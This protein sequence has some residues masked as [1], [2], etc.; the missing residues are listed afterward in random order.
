[1][2]R[3]TTVLAVIVLLAASGAHAAPSL[4][5]Q[6]AVFDSAKGQFYVDLTFLGLPEAGVR[7][8]GVGLGIMLSGPGTTHVTPYANTASPH[9]NRYGTATG[10]ALVAPDTYAWTWNAEPSNS[11][12]YPSGRVSFSFL[13]QDLS[14][15][16]IRNGYVAGRVH[17][18]WDRVLPSPSD[19]IIHV[20]YLDDSYP[21][22]TYCD[23]DLEFHDLQVTN[24]DLAVPEPATLSLLALGAAGL[25]AARRRAAR[26]LS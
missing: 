3:T 20:G 9:P 7:M 8:C 5:I 17:W 10:A 4:T 12:L 13:P 2:C 23:S 16:L 6:E 1:M 25:F 22:P 15:G 14:S 26:A 24:N 19:I 11:W 18:Q 21:L